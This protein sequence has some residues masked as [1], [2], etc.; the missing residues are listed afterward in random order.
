[1]SKKEKQLVIVSGGTRCGKS[2][3]I[4]RFLGGLAVEDVRF[5]YDTRDDAALKK[6]WELAED[7]LVVECIVP[8]HDD[9]ECIMRC[10][11]VTAARRVEVVRHNGALCSA[12]ESVIFLMEVAG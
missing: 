7:G 4:R 1:M 11:G 8:S 2:D 3:Y 6:A 5:Y 9:I 10:L 12:K